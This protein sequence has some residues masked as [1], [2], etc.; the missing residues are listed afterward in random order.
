LVVLKN[1]LSLLYLIC[2]FIFINIFIYYVT[3]SNQDERIK[4][5]LNANINNLKTHYEILLHHQKITADTAMKSTLAMSNVIDILKKA[6]ISNNDEKKELRDTLYNLLKDKYNL[7]KQ[8][9]VLQYH[10]LLASNESFLRMHK[11]SKFGD[12]LTHIRDDF[13]Y[14][15]ETKKIVRGFA[16]GRTAHGFR[17]IYP[18]FDTDKNYIGSMEVSFS[19][20]NF[21]EYLT[22]IS[23]IH[24]HFLVDKNIFDFKA[25]ER[26]D[27]VLKYLQSSE[28]EEFMLTMN[29]AHTKEMC[30]IENNK[31]LKNVRED[32]RKGIKK[33]EQ[34]ALY[35]IHKINHVDV[36]SF[37]PIKDITNTKTLAW[38]VSYEDSDFIYST[39][40]NTLIM[41][42]TLFILFAVLFYF[43]H[44][45]LNQKNVLK[46]QV[47]VQTEFLL[48]ANKKLQIS[49][50][51]LRNLNENLEFKIKEEVEK[52]QQIQN[53]LFK[54]EK[55]ASMG[56]MIGNIAHQWRQPLSA[57]STAAT[58]M[59]VQKEYGILKDDDFN[60]TCES[61]N[62]N[63]QYLSK[64]IDDFKC[65]IKD[66]KVKKVFDLEFQIKKFLLLIDNI[67]SDENIKIVLNLESDIKIDGYNNE[68]VQCFLNIFNNTKD[69]LKKQDEE[70]RLFFISTFKKEDKIIIE[71][72][73]NGG[74][75][76]DDIKDKIFEPYFTTK[77]QSQGTG[78][79]LHMTYDIIVSGMDG[80]IEASNVTYNYQNKEYIGA[81]IKIEL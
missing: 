40:R 64:T 42:I 8:K 70:N 22:N 51:E 67:I 14:T 33:G 61:I 18:I 37:L 21:Q 73:D 57:I 7:L 72:K 34:F 4:I 71:F 36:V 12:N 2:I 52:N 63:S 11:K 30:I 49:E 1:K 43:I 23:K 53:Q 77:H 66:D 29:G 81:L 69:V 38:L 59:Q 60:K 62:R 20:D 10:F 48:K 32:I 31:K 25:W 75:I 39:V 45:T 9:G 56:E 24:T 78:L 58:G 27:L 68:L 26:D 16:Q 13:R 35:V 19:S 54:S 44:R 50:L 76:D 47:L 41:R 55:L 46:H 15:S 5:A 74:G 6:N 65:F 80:N 79:G 28:H 3:K 17:N